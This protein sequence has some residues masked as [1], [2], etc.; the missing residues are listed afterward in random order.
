[1][2]IYL[3]LSFI[4]QS[5][6]N[7]ETTPIGLAL[8]IGIALLIACVIYQTRN[9][10][11]RQIDRLFY[12]DSYQY[13]HELNEFAKKRIRGLISLNELGTELLTLLCGAI[14]C[15]Q[16]YLLLPRED[17]GD[18]YIRFAV[19][20]KEDRPSLIIKRDSPVMQWLR[21]NNSYLSKERLEEAHEF[22]AFW[23]EEK[24]SITQLG[25]QL[26]FPTV[27]RRKI[28]GVLALGEKMVKAKYTREDISLSERAVNDVATSLEKEY[29]SDQ[30]KKREQ[31][32]SII[33]RL[34]GVI[35]SSLNIQ[36]VYDAFVKELKKVVEADFTAIA[37]VEENEIYFSALST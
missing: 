5:L 20:L 24:E 11:T 1:M 9:F 6:F 7:V 26:F 36:E 8:S 28:I 3:L 14:K 21:T 13:R 32:L 34:A 31:E 25:I 17:T 30:L 23:Q 15:R 4:G 37:L 29:L 27:S 19:P 33:N 35:S 2:L 12:R 22:K 16:S 18:F 10:A